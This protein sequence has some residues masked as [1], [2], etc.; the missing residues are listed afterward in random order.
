MKNLLH[1]MIVLAAIFLIISAN[2]S[3]TNYGQRDLVL[4]SSQ[5]VGLIVEPVREWYSM[6]TDFDSLVGRLTR[7]LPFYRVSR[8]LTGDSRQDILR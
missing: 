5:S 1:T 3:A 6:T 2:S 8:I 4:S 7:A